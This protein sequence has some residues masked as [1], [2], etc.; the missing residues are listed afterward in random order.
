MGGRKSATID[1]KTVE[2]MAW[3]ARIELTEEEKKL[4]AEQCGRILDYFTKIDSLDTRETPP[5][6]HAANLTNVFRGDEV[7]PSLNVREALRNAR[8]KKRQMFKVSRML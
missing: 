6:Y 5:T 1:V 4:F 3:L 2:R 7:K 8:D